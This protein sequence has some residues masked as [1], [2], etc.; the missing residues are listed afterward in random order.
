MPLRIIRR[1]DTGTLYIVGTVTPAGAET[2]HRIRQRAGSDREDEAREEAAAIELQIIRNHHLGHRPVERH[3]AAAVTA[4]L[5]AEPRTRRTVVT[6]EKLMRHFGRMPLRAINQDS[7]DAARGI[8]IT[9]DA[10]PG[11]VRRNLI[12]PVRA[13]LM[14]AARRGWCDAPR[15]DL[16][17]EPRGRTAFLLPDQFEKIHAA[18]PARVRPLLRFLVCTGCRLGETLALEW[19][20]VDLRAG[21]AR[22]WADQTKG[23]REHIVRLPPA[24]VAALAGLPHRAGHVFRSRYRDADGELLPYRTSDDGGG[25][26]KRMLDRAA[27]G[28]TPVSPHMLRHTWAT[29]HWALHRDLLALRDAGG[30]SSVALVERYAHLM[31]AGCEDAIRR[32]W[33][34]G[35]VQMVEKRA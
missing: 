1:P 11:T 19:S 16:P 17:R 28:V 34:L 5:S 18:A 7:I 15:F 23:G 13:I 6:A 32:A 8:V 9:A 14:F 12:V 21:Q 2:G 30:W 35:G 24:A 25:Q 22:L 20:Q 33:G 4:Y 27:A 31:P 3:F 26:I 10:A 29:W